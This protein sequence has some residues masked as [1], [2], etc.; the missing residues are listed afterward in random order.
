VENGKIYIRMEGF[1]GVIYD[2]P[3][4]DF[5]LSVVNV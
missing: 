3:V 5:S 4:D 2:G 1:E